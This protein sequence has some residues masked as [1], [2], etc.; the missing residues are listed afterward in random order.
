MHKT[1]G[2]KAFI[3]AGAV[4]L[5]ADELSESDTQDSLDALL[6]SQAAAT[7]KI[8][9]LTQVET[10]TRANKMAMRVTGAM[11]LDNPDANFPV[12]MPGRFS[13]LGLARQVLGEWIPETVASVMDSNVQLRLEQALAA[14]AIEELQQHVVHQDKWVRFMFGVVCP[15]LTITVV[16]IAFAFDEP[17]VDNV[18]RHRFNSEK[19]LGNLYVDGYKALAD[20]EDYDLSRATIIS[21][22]GER[23]HK[24]IIALD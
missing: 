18:L 21:L 15:D 12:S 8:T 10:W 19:V 3:C 16:L 1:L 14:P 9:D 22:L 4:I 24:Q 20:P 23:R 13:L 7:N 6:Y 2:F 11:L 17:I 5:V